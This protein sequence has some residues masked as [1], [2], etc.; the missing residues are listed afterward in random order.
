MATKSNKGNLRVSPGVKSNDVENYPRLS[1]VRT[2][3]DREF[4]KSND[5]KLLKAQ[6]ILG[7]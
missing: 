6:Q 3:N 1:G 7:Q 2:G 4:L 5:G